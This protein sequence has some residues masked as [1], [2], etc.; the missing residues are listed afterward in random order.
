MTYDIH[1]T[2][3]PEKHG[4]LEDMLAHGMG[5]G[6]RIEAEILERTKVIRFDNIDMQ[7]RS[8]PDVMTST[9]FHD[10]YDRH[11]LGG[12]GCMAHAEWLASVIRGHEIDVLRVKIET[13]PWLEVKD[14]VIESHIRIAGRFEAW[15]GLL[16]SMMLPSLKRFYTLRTKGSSYRDHMKYLN[17][18]VEQLVQ[19]RRAILDITTELVGYD[20]NPEHDSAW[21]S[22]SFKK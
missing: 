14:P 1:I 5:A 20:S 6:D 18:E 12:N 22:G 7:G 4:Y 21:E 8:C 19:C 2:I 15:P 17:S 9:K 3:D 11:L 10:P 13:L 16:A